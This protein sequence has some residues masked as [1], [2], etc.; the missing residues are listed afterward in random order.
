MPD[1]AVIAFVSGR[2]TKNKKVLREVDNE[3]VIEVH[4]F[5]TPVATVDRGYGLTVALGKF[6]FA[7]VDVRLTVPCHT[8]DI[9]VADEYARDWCEKRIEREI[10]NIRGGTRSNGGNKP[11]Y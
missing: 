5:E 4:K 10:A 8:E 1:N 3:E 11:K 2:W 6:E 7:R 9:D